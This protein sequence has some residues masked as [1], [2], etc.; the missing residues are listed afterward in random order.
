MWLHYLR[1]VWHIVLKVASHTEVC[2][3]LP[4]SARELKLSFGLK[5]FIGH[6][7]TK[8]IHALSKKFNIRVSNVSLLGFKWQVVPAKNVNH[9]L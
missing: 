5:F 4:K 3:L 7:K 9:S 6:G 2:L 1:M 8:G